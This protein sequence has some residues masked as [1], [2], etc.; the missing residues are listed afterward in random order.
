ME[1]MQYAQRKGAVLFFSLKSVDNF[2]ILGSESIKTAM[3]CNLFTVN[4]LMCHN[5]IE[6]T[7]WYLNKINNSNYLYSA[8]LT[9]YAQKSMSTPAYTNKACTVCVCK[10]TTDDTAIWGL[11]LTSS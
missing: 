8:I 1:N 3:K 7:Y 2:T 6:I 5:L 9:S 11:F 10:T 4:I